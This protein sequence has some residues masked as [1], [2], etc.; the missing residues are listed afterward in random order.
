MSYT[1]LLLSNQQDDVSQSSPADIDP[2]AGELTASYSRLIHSVICAVLLVTGS[3]YTQYVVTVNCSVSTVGWDCNLSN[4][5]LCCAYTLE[6]PWEEVNPD[7]GRDFQEEFEFADGI[8]DQLREIL[9]KP[10]LPDS[11]DEMNENGKDDRISIDSTVG[12]EG[13]TSSGGTKKQESSR[14]KSESRGK[15]TSSS[16]DGKRQSN[17]SATDDHDSNSFTDMIPQSS[18]TPAIS[19]R[20]L[21]RD[22]EMHLPLS[23]RSSA[24]AQS[25]V[26]PTGKAASYLPHSA[27]FGSTTSEPPVQSKQVSVGQ[28]KMLRSR[29]KSPSVPLSRPVSVEAGLA[30][31]SL[32]RQ[33]SPVQRYQ[34][35]PLYHS[36]GGSQS[37]LWDQEKVG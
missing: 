37:I 22:R 19:E 2:G 7:A 33:T 36:R 4:V 24:E 17:C 6:F 3:Q 11:A 20:G 18:S 32:Q 28:H 5:H 21:N 30:A 31:M 27:S 8:S 26:S 34:S 15:R 9:A 12:I 23:G 16:L 1:C 25:S 10:G 14:N 35:V 13:P 29:R